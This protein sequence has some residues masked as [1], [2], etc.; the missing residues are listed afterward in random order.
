MLQNLNILN[1]HIL[2]VKEN[3]WDGELLNIL[4]EYVKLEKSKRL[5]LSKIS[6]GS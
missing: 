3:Q 5:Y 6:N 2:Q 1:D 4:E